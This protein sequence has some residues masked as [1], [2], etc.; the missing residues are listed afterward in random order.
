VAN[1]RSISRRGM[2]GTV[3]RAGAVGLLAS[4]SRF[5]H[6]ATTSPEW[7][8]MAVAARKEGKISVNTFTGQGYARILKLFRRPTRRSSSSTRTSSPS[9]SR[10]A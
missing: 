4:A 7:E 3:A 1:E 9:S 6:A 2:L 5:A 8:Q 10:R